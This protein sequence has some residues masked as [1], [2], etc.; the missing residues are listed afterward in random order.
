MVRQPALLQEGLSL[1]NGHLKRSDQ[2]ETILFYYQICADTLIDFKN[3]ER[4]RLYYVYNLQK[5]AIKI[6]SNFLVSTVK[7][8]IPSANLS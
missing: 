4:K 7:A 8:S 2:T 3:R 1:K 5:R 6:S